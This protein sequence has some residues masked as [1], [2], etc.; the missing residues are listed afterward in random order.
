MTNRHKFKTNN[1]Q[2]QPQHSIIISSIHILF[3]MMVAMKLFSLG[4]IVANVMVIAMS[5][6]LA[7]SSTGVDAFS[8]VI[9][10]QQTRTRQPSQQPSL[11]SL[12]YLM[13]E[14]D[15]EEL[16]DSLYSKK[17]TNVTPR[18]TS[19][20]PTTTSTG[21]DTDTINNFVDEKMIED[22]QNQHLQMI[23]MQQ[24][25]VHQ[26]QQ[27]SLYTFKIPSVSY[28][29][30]LSSVSPITATATATATAII[31][32]SMTMMSTITAVA[33]N[34]VNMA[35]IYNKLHDDLTYINIQLLRSKLAFLHRLLPKN[36]KQIDRFVNF[37]IQFIL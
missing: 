26:H 2:K 11:S 20:I 31:P 12:A 17:T 37:L 13:R 5:V 1:I 6:L 25:Q 4:V 8:G 32:P 35:G 21:T 3:N 15:D 30:P 7:A 23:Q 29:Q 10:K 24:Q 14:G 36:K 16:F 9:V 18:F 34:N 22:L 33:T 28:A 19:I 27:Q